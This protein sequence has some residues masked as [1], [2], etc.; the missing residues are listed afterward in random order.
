MLSENGGVE[1]REAGQLGDCVQGAVCAGCHSGVRLAVSCEWQLCNKANGRAL[2]EPGRAPEFCLVTW[3][4]V[5]SAPT[6]PRSNKAV[7]PDRGTSFK[8]ISME[9][10][11]NHAGGVK[12]KL[13]NKKG[14]VQN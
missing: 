1:V 13:W 12:R 7:S 14:K 5:T 2:I 4:N 8:W 10:Q 11:E 6:L 3:L 9:Q